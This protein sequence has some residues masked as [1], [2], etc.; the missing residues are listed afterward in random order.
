MA[1]PLYT[2]N[3]AT[4]L[5]SGIN[6]SATSLTVASGA[7][8]L[9]PSPTGGN[10]FYVTLITADSTGSEIV[11][12]TAR[13]VDTLTITRG[14]EG[15]T[16]RSFATGDSVQLRVTAQGLVDIFNNGGVQSISGSTNVVVSSSTGTPTISLPTTITSN[17]S[18]NAATAS[19][20]T[21]QASTDNSTNIATTAFVKTVVSGATG[22]LGTMSSQNANN[23]AITGGT[24]NGVTGTNSGLTVGN[25]TIAGSATTAS[26]ISTG[27]GLQNMAPTN[28]GSL[29]IG[30]F[31]DYTGS[32]PTRNW[33]DSV[34][35]GSILIAYRAYQA[36][37]G[38]C[39]SFAGFNYATLS[40]TWRWLGGQNG[41]ALFVR[42]A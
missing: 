5:A 34:S 27:G 18:G 24:I 30:A 23:V 36:G 39:G 31:N 33:G 37:G 28:I 29:T 8:S 2:N 19:Q 21:T 22:A 7:G 40:G 38:C 12:C 20:S 25:A 4:V 17:T 13:S 3:A 9:F 14:Q 1:Q 32:G 35:G 15:T 16:A 42:I 11:K 10:Y 26:S 41:S 6:A